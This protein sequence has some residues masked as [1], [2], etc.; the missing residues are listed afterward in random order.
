M[1][2]KNLNNIAKILLAFGVLASPMVLANQVSAD[3]SIANTTDTTL[4]AQAESAVITTENV[5]SNVVS[6]KDESEP[7]EDIKLSESETN[8]DE[9]RKQST[10]NTELTTETISEDD[11]N[12]ETISEVTSSQSKDEISEDK[13][14]TED[15]QFTLTNSQKEELKKAGCSDSEISKIQEDIKSKL[16][17]DKEF[18]VKSYLNNIIN[19]YNNTLN[20]SDYVKKQPLAAANETEA[21]RDIS[22]D[23]T[24]AEIHIGKT[25]QEG[26]LDAGNGEGLAWSVAFKAP[27]DTKAGDYFD[28]NLSDNWT[29]KGI[30]SDTDNANPININ[31]VTVADGKRLSRQKIRYTFNENIKNLDEIRVAVQYGGYDVKEKVKDSKTQ[32][33]TVSVGDHSDSKELYVDYGKVSYDSHQTGINGKSNYT[34]FDPKTGEFTQVFYINP[35]SKFIQSA[36]N[37]YFN[38]TVGVVIRNKDINF[39]ETQVDFVNNDV[40]VDV[41]KVPA[42]THMPDAVYENPVNG[43]SDS[44]IKANKLQDGS[45]SIDLG[46]TSIDNPYIITIK[47]KINPNVEVINLGSSATIYGNGNADLTL[48]NIIHLQTGNT[49]GTGVEKKGSFIEHHIYITKDKDGKETSRKVEDGKLQEGKKDQSYTTGKVEKDGFEF[50]R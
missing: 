21:G 7:K 30:E 19:S 44:N 27:D 32:T 42:R 11:E 12:I 40:S 38:G 8:K 4:K 35:D 9:V 20:I 17:I 33:F 47:S 3:N 16:A 41:V 5:V 49:G 37:E 36:N 45:I 6:N 25:K 26:V 13:L 28:I 22:N 48:A 23:I 2:K 31:G 50:V 24:E 15:A 29:L 18:D 46:R 10:D 43:E 34:A 1:D 39:N 14:T